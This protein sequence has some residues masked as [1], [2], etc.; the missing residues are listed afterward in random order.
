MCAVCA[1]SDVCLVAGVWQHCCTASPTQRQVSAHLRAPILMFVCAGARA[2]AR[3]ALVL[4]ERRWPVRVH[5]ALS[6]LDART[7]RAVAEARAAAAVAAVRSCWT[8]L[9]DPCALDRLLPRRLIPRR[10]H[11]SLKSRR[12]HAQRPHVHLR[13]LRRHR[14][15]RRLRRARHACLRRS[16]A[17]RRC[18][19]A[20]SCRLQHRLRYRRRLTP[21][22][23]SRC[24]CR[25]TR[26]H[27]TRQR[28]RSSQSCSRALPNY[29]AILSSSDWRR[30]R[31][32]HATRRCDHTALI[33]HSACHSGRR[34]R[35][36]WRPAAAALA[37]PTTCAHTRSLLRR[38]ACDLF[39]GVCNACVLGVAA[40]SGAS[41]G[42]RGQQCA[43]HSCAHGATVR[44][45]GG[46]IACGESCA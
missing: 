45:A 2:A 14:R 10:L 38:C 21:T 37:R 17:W 20:R 24:S 18:Q 41:R 4:A 27:R 40:E 22:P 26:A 36:R 9:N 6:T 31:Y 34:R 19:R 23:T 30:C 12:L 8:F 46:L 11:L 29:A 33:T 16:S 7:L 13:A 39:V 43:A 32:D 25:R 15:H 3:R 28:A 35:A 42:A 44:S 5:A 1:F